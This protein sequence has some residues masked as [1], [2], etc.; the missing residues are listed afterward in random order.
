M[1]AGAATTVDSDEFKAAMAAQA[2]ESAVSSITPEMATQLAGMNM[3]ETITLLPGGPHNGF[4]HWNLY[5]DDKSA[6][7]VS[8]RGS[9]YVC[10]FES[11]M[12][13]VALSD[14]ASLHPRA[15]CPN[16]WIE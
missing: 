13:V 7:K 8:S 2:G 9:A 16:P 1:Q 10:I 5:G 3:V 12:S 4:E 15:S 6:L 14:T 11:E